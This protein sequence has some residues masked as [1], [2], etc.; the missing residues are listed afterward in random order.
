ML[1]LGAAAQDHYGLE[2]PRLAVPRGPDDQADDAEARRYSSSARR[3]SASDSRGN[4]GGAE[5]TYR[6]SLAAYAA[7]GGRYLPQRAFTLRNLADNLAQRG[8]YVEADSLVRE[9]IDIISRSESPYHPD[10]GLAWIQLGA[11]DR[12][13]GNLALAR[14]ETDRGSSILAEAG[15]IARRLFVKE[16]MQKALLLLAEGKPVDANAS[17]LV[18]LDSAA[19]EF[20]RDDALRRSAGRARRDVAGAAPADGRHGESVRELRDISQDPRTEAS[21]D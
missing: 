7:V 2:H 16:K 11:I 3:Y 10:V 21:G 8:Q 5:R 17:M 14:T 20:T 13:V 6:E 18:A 4:T 1:L 12:A 9:A 19:T 15:P